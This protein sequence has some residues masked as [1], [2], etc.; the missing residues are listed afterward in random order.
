MPKFFLSAVDFLFNGQRYEET[1]SGNLDSF[2]LYVHAEKAIF[3]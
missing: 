1:Q 3:Y 2:R